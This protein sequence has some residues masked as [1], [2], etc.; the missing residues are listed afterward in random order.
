MTVNYRKITVS[1]NKLFKLLID[2]GLKKGQ[3]ALITGISPSSV[4][5]LGKG[6]NVNVDVLVRICQELNCTMD[7]I[8]EIAPK[9][10]DQHNKEQFPS[11]IV[12]P[13]CH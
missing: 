12:E 6:A 7:D 10:A 13:C 4:A 1:Y 5:K 2:K 8:M 9:V 11:K 3:F